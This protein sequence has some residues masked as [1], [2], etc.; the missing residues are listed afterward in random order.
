MQSKVE[1]TFDILDVTMKLTK[2]PFR[3]H[4]IA[5]ARYKFP[6]I[7]WIFFVL[8]LQSNRTHLWK[9]V[10]F[11]FFFCIKTNF[12]RP[13]PT[14]IEGELVKPQNCICD[15]PR[16]PL[17]QPCGDVE[18]LWRWSYVEGRVGRKQQQKPD[19]VPLL[20]GYQKQEQTPSGYQGD[21]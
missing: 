5:F 6:W 15:Q 16:S 17:L 12:D 1:P 9:E 4:G 3:A 19:I 14:R 8:L 21:S 2:I 11:F 18:F 13:D 7:T 10:M 20:G